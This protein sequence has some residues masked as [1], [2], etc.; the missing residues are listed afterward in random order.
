M[1]VH[2][3]YIKLLFAL[4]AP[5]YNECGYFYQCNCFR[6]FS[7][8]CDYGLFKQGG[9]CPFLRF[10]MSYFYINILNPFKVSCTCFYQLFFYIF[11]LYWQLLSVWIRI[12]IFLLL[13][14]SRLKGLSFH[15]SAIFIKRI[16]IGFDDKEMQSASLLDLLLELMLIMFSDIN[17]YTLLL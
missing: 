15:F 5:L 6:A 7:C 3:I 13:I 17:A 2:C 12:H 16:L 8:Y 14:K 1:H 10:S 4:K 9:K 11:F